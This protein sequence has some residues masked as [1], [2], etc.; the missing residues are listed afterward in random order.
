MNASEILNQIELGA[1]ALPQFQHGYV[2]NRAQVRETAAGATS[3]RFF[4]DP[5]AFLTYVERELLG[6]EAA[7]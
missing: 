3:V 6:D 5:A 1:I 7:A 4:T 2:W